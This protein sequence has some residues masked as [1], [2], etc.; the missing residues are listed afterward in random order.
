MLDFALAHPDVDLVIKHKRGGDSRVF[1][2]KTLAE[3]KGIDD[4]FSQYRNVTVVEDGG[5]QDLVQRSSAVIAI[6]STTMI[7]ALL[8]GKLVLIPDFGDLFEGKS[9]N[10]FHNYPILVSTF[11][12]SRELAMA[13]DGGQPQSVDYEAAREQFLCDYLVTGG[14]QFSTP[15]VEKNLM[16]VIEGR[17]R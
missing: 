17:D 13:I 2:A 1:G 12:S 14:H 15:L 10:L 5:A 6:N 4:I 9:W 3:L 7:E 8:A 11:L 16:E